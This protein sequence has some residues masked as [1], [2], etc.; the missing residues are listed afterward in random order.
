MVLP[1][2]RITVHWVLVVQGA[3]SVWAENCQLLGPLFSS[4][5]PTACGLLLSVGW[6]GSFMERGFLSDAD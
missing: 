2:C 1:T 4:P 5:S 3:K 6:T